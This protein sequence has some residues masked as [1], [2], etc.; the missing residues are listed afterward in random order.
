MDFLRT[1]KKRT[2]K[3]A[4]ASEGERSLASKGSA[5]EKG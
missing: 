5:K 2:P 1:L 4:R 3:A